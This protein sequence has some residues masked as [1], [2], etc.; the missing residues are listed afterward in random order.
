MG[1]KILS[2]FIA[3]SF[4]SNCSHFPT[5]QK[6]DTNKPTKLA[7][8]A[9]V[10]VSALPA[11]PF[12]SVRSNLKPNEPASSSNTYRLLS[13][14]K[15][16]SVLDSNRSSS[17]LAFQANLPGITKS[18]TD[19]FTRD[20]DGEGNITE[21]QDTDTTRTS[22]SG[23]QPNV[24]VSTPDLAGISLLQSGFSPN[25]DLEL[26]M[27]AADYLYQRAKLNDAMFEVDLTRPGYQLWVVRLNIDVQPNVRKMPYDVRTNIQIGDHQ[28][29]V[30]LIPLFATNNYETAD[31]TTLISSLSQLNASLSGVSGGVGLGAG[32]ERKIEQL[33][34]SIGTDINTKISVAVR[35]KNEL[36]VRLPAAYSPKSEYELRD[37]NYKVTM[38]AYAKSQCSAGTLNIS[39]TWNMYDAQQ[40][41]AVQ[42]TL[43][44]AP[45]STIYLS[46]PEDDLPRHQNVEYVDDGKTQ[47]TLAAYGI[48]LA[49]VAELD[50][51]IFQITDDHKPSFANASL[52]CVHLK[53]LKSTDAVTQRTAKVHQLYQPK[54]YSFDDERFVA[55][56]PSISA[57]AS[58]N[59]KPWYLGLGRKN[60]CSTDV[61]FRCYPMVKNKAASGKIAVATPKFK[62]G[63]VSSTV[64]QSSGSGDQPKQAKVILYVSAVKGQT[65]PSTNFLVKISNAVIPSGAE[66]INMMNGTLNPR[67]QTQLTSNSFVVS[68]DS[69]AEITLRDVTNPKVQVEI[70]PWDATNS[71]AVKAA[72]SQSHILE[73]K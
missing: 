17:S 68:L 32:Y 41:N 69:T 16:L 28:N 49:P 3:I 26:A 51:N 54:S 58:P 23:E 10:S 66:H 37:Q 34:E 19:S 38:L 27:E 64:F 43:E 5:K 62:S 12:Y 55:N 29:D 61:E 48:K 45:N 56:F 4:L 14:E 13:V 36:S 7:D 21:T 11:V 46:H 52:A 35:G 47:T 1:A 22:S 59:S 39:T 60:Q 2:S 42:S 57:S 15:A 31:L 67:T 18:K 33:V 24:S 53:N 44:A 40:G 70:I 50:A 63:L 30:Q 25:L 20:V 65:S 9:T 8:A 73:I 72:E 71:V 6:Y